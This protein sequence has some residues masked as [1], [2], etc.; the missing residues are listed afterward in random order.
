VIPV[1]GLEQ[2]RIAWVQIRGEGYVIYGFI[3]YT[4]SDSALV[5]YMQTG[6]LEL[7]RISGPECAI[8]IIE[9]PSAKWVEMAKKKNHPWWRL[10]GSTASLSNSP[11]EVAQASLPNRDHLLQ[12]LAQNKPFIV[13]QVE[14]GEVVSQKHLL[15]PNY[16]SLYDRN[17]AL[18]IAEFFGIVP[19]QVP[20]LIFFKDF[21]NDE[22]DITVADLTDIRTQWQMKRYFRRFFSSSEFKQILKN[23][24]ANA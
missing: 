7:D 15:E 17:E 22:E 4:D 18:E 12:A 1:L 20:C 19:S 9:S 6:L 24:R 14:P 2:A 16:Q 21:D 10:F 13:F 11:A 5:E 8:F 3:L 23:A